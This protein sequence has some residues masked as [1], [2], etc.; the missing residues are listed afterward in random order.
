A[1]HG[2]LE[3]GGFRPHRAADDRLGRLRRRPVA[4]RAPG[5]PGSLDAAGSTGP[6]QRTAAGLPAPLAPAGTANATAGVRM[7]VAPGT[8]AGVPGSQP[9]RVMAATS[10][11][12]S[13]IAAAAT[14]ASACSGDPVPGIGS[15]WGDLAS[16]QVRTICRGL[17][18]CRLA[19]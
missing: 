7:A 12:L 15:I 17:A 13:S 6:G 19:A 14:L 8:V 1:G 2:H 16:S 11:G 9:A 10:S 5:W 18:P 3:H 4:L